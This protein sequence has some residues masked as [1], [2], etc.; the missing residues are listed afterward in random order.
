ML[1]ITEIWLSFCCQFVYAAIQPRV[2]LS[3][4]GEEGDNNLSFKKYLCNLRLLVK[5]PSSNRFIIENNFSQ[6]ELN[7]NNMIENFYCTP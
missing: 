5:K 3:S 1:C 7:F 2:R 6:S 4:W